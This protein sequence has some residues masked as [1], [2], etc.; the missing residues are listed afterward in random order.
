M[1]SITMYFILSILLICFSVS[2]EVNYNVPE[3]DVIPI[4]DGV[5]SAN[6]WDDAIH[7][8]IY[9]PDI[10]T[11]PKEGMLMGGAPDDDDDLSADWYFKWDSE[12]LYLACRVHDEY[13]YWDPVEFDGFWRGDVARL[14]FSLLDNQVGRIPEYDFLPDT[15]SGGG[16][17]FYI[18]K[19][20]LSNTIMDA[21]ILADGWVMEVAIYWSDYENYIPRPG[22]Q[23]GVAL[24]HPDYD[25]TS[26]DSYLTDSGNGSWTSVFVA[27][28]NTLTLV[29]ANGC[30]EQGH[31]DQDLNGDCT[32]DI[33]DV[34]IFVSDWL[35]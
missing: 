6:E 5:L 33:E 2:A 25:G 32:V 28:Y 16:P 7:I 12:M 31:W 18:P 3:A 21:T 9:Y 11:A 10:A 14:G 26:A 30:G 8:P 34:A 17:T 22:D 20:S 29:A 24:I 4:I 15:S 27:P 13:L 1:K 19:H 23:H 35:Y